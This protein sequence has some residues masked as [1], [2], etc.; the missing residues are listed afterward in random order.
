MA[1]SKRSSGGARQV[2][3]TLITRP[4]RTLI[5]ANRGEIACRI[6]RT[7]RRLGI[8]T[9]A[10]YS[11]ADARALH[12]EMADEAVRLGPAPARDSYLAVARLMA[13]ARQTSADAIHPGYGFLSESEALAAACHQAGLAFVGPSL[14]AIRAMGSKS[15]AKALMTASGV[16]LVPGYHGAAQDLTTFATEAARVGY[17]VL[18]KASAGGGGK[19][20]RIV[21]GPTALA[22]AVDGAKRESIKSFGD[23][24]LLIEKLIERPRHIEVQV[25][26]DTR[27]HVVSLFERECT[28]QRRHQ[29]VI[30]EA[31]S[32]TLDGQQRAAISQA[33]RAAAAAIGYASAGTVEFIADATQFYFIEMNTRLQVE[34]PVTEMITGLDLVEWQLRVAEGEPLPLTQAQID[35][36]GPKGHAVEARVYAED[37]GRGFLPATGRVTQWLPPVPAEG[38]RIDTGVRAGDEIGLH[39]DPMLAKVIVHASTRPAAFDRLAQALNAFAIAG[40]TTNLGFLEALA[41]HGDV[42]AGRMDTGLIER[43]LAKLAPQQPAPDPGLLGLAAAA[44]LQLER[45]PQPHKTTDAHS[46]WTAASGWSLTGPR[47]RTLSF[48][49]ASQKCDV[50][51]VYTRLGAVIETPAGALP[52]ITTARPDGRLDITIAGVQAT[53]AAAFTAGQLTL[54]AP[55]GR[56][57]MDLID[58]Y[59]PSRDNAA[60]GAAFRAPMP[61]TVTRVLSKPGIALQ[62]GDAVLVLEAMKMEHTLRAPSRGH[63]KQLNCAVGDVV[64]EGAELA[65]FAPEET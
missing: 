7:A 5:I 52:I 59:A 18:V 4:I 23:D 64:A 8:R 21:T 31:P 65:I 53:V 60:A 43:E 35:A 32:A 15:A 41:R 22:E 6:M 34:H 19:G 61:G 11:D 51:I 54:T 62:T 27:G 56:L 28:L 37:A 26:G 47:R 33:A 58:P 42:L 10:V 17:P 29:K 40:V 57:R 12:V 45:V 14:E 9:V 50:T 20:M 39:Y 55:A 49:H 3:R 30:E 48:A 24:H 44:V 25:F 1:S 13:A 38:L 46:P 2:T 63:V 16:P 36:I